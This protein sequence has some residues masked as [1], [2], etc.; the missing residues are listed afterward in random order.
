MKQIVR[1]SCLSFTVLLCVSLTATLA[2]AQGPAI[3]YQNH[4]MMPPGMIG[5][6]QLL[7]GGPLAGYFQPVQI[8]PAGNAQVSP[9][10]EGQFIAADSG[11]LTVGLLIGQVY[12]FQVT[13]IPFHEGQELYPTVEV[14]DRLYPPAGSKTR[15]PIPIHLTQEELEFALS[16][17]LVTRVIYLESPRTALPV[18]QQAGDQRITDANKQDDPLQIADALGRPVAILR[19]G[20]RIPAENRPSDSFLF[21]SPP[22]ET[23]R[24]TASLES[25]PPAEASASASRKPAPILSARRVLTE[26]VR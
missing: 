2:Q 4:A 24:S 9:V 10:R 25:R 16:G 17:R 5:Q 26:T 15:F 22:L 3:H 6:G 21:G 8:V 19:I 7:R 18:S 23:Y 12:R 11:P 1:K 14:I 20:S 13:G